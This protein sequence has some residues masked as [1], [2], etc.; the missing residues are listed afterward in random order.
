MIKKVLISL[1]FA[2]LSGCSMASFE[3]GLNYEKT[4]Y[5]KYKDNQSSSTTI[6]K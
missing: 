3:K 6:K 5:Y 2:I 1:G 4:P